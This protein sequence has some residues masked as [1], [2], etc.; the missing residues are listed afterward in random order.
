M[1]STLEDLRGKREELVGE[2]EAL[3]GAENFDPK[4]E[5]FVQARAK[6][7]ALD[8]KIKSLVEWHTS[9]DAANAIDAIEVRG[10]KTA[11]VAIKE[12]KEGLSPGQIFTRSR[13]YEDYKSSPRGTSGRVSV[14][15]ESLIQTR[16]PILTTT[17][18]GIIPP[19][20]IAPSAPPA[21]QTPLLGVIDRIPVTSNS[22][23]WVTYPA[24]G[25]PAAVTAEGAA[26]TETTIAP[27]LV[28]VTLETIASWLTVSRQFN[29][30]A[31]ALRA[32][33]D[34]AM[35]RGIIDKMEAQA[36]AVLTGATLPITTNT[37]GTL[38]A[39]IRRGIA[40][41]QAAGYDPQIAVL[42]PS[43]YASIDLA[44][45]GGTLRGPVVNGSFF[46][47]RPVPVGAVPSGTAYVGDFQTGMAW[48]ARNDVVMY[49]TDSHASNFVSNLIT[50]LAETRGKAVIHR[51]EA[52][53]KVTG[54]V[55]PLLTQMSEQP[56]VTEA[57]SVPAAKK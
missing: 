46:G 17:F 42:N 37:T 2:I 25:A 41:V 31:G 12:A 26:K 18:A 1:S 20:R 44:V 27:L 9:R 21:Q 7:E 48:L 40:T 50:L 8:D 3:T 11:E 49:E 57:K 38:L 54:T 43:D 51:A 19:D 15:L 47:I 39:G 34:A 4:D 56:D 5:T 13:A 6:A 14:D 53:T 23:E 32:Y 28:T 52:L 36:A 29:E 22:V 10:K 24:A 33:I 55:T 35:R 30:D 16:A 45:M